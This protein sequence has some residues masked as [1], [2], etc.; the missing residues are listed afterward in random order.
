MPAQLPPRSFTKAL[1]AF[2]SIDDPL[3]R[4]AAVQ[5]AREAL[6]SL[7]HAT[8]AQARAAGATWGE[9]GTLYGVSKQ[10]VQQRFRR[11]GELAADPAA[12][13]TSGKSKPPKS[14]DGSR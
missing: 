14:A 5:H 2:G 4:L 13:R 10:A 8:V 9:I 12:P 7:E 11:P 1:A 3:T 6:E